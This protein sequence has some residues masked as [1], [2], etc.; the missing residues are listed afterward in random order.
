M[1]SEYNFAL[2]T[3]YSFASKSKT[4]VQVNLN[5]LE[6]QEF[7]GVE[8]P[9]QQCRATFP[10]FGAQGTQQ[11]AT[12]YFELEPGRELGR[13]I[14]SAEELLV[15]LEGELEAEVN[16]HLS[17]A[18]AGDIILVPERETHNLRNKGNGRARV[19]GVFGGA[20]QIVAEFE[21]S[22]LPLHSNRVNTRDL[23][24]N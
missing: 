13:H 5:E 24:N 20:N 23:M 16:G 6:L 7:T 10:L 19:L 11:L 4:M 2:S 22:W 1:S 12:V 17:S 18:R 14:D 15:V 21:Q 9:L 8:N 3:P